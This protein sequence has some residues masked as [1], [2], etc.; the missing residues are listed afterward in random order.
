MASPDR[1]KGLSTTGYA[2]L[3]LLS[4]REWTAY[5]LEQQAKRSLHYISPR[6]RSVVYAEPKKLVRHG[7]ATARTEQ[8]GRRTVAVYSITDAGWAALRAWAATPAEFPTLEAP[9]LIRSLFAGYGDRDGLV[10][11]LRTQHAEAGAR[12]GELRAQAGSYRDGGSPFP[13]RLPWIATNGAFVAGY[14]RL[15]QDWSEWA[16]EQA[17]AFSDDPVAA[18]EQALAVLADL[19][20]G[21]S[22]ASSP[23]EGPPGA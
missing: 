20:A 19:A 7:L 13:D 18:R 21:F 8:R 1:V 23:P 3:S 5:E 15:L 10:A 9:M 4:L 12:L 16:A 11:A 14:L 2:V 22:P 17:V 6:A